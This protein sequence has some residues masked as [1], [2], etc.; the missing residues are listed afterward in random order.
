MK[1]IRHIVSLIL[2]VTVLVIVPLSIE[3]DFLVKNIPAS[4]VGLLLIAIGLCLM[5]ISIS[6]FIRLGHGTLA[7]WSPTIHLVTTGIYSYVRNPMIIG[8]LIILSGEALAACSKNIAI[9]A[10]VFFIINNLYFR[11]YEEPELERKFGKSYRDYRKKVP[12]WI[13]LFGKPKL[14]Y[15]SDESI[16]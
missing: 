9:W 6:K 2:P 10:I 14:E 16:H 13:P 3:N 8:V 5:V 12:R 15:E 4:L 1:M 7:P 11:I